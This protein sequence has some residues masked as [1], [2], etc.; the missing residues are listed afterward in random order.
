MYVHHDLEGNEISLPKL[1][2]EHVNMSFTYFKPSIPLYNVI[3]LK[4]VNTEGRNMSSHSEQCVQQLSCV[5]SD[6]IHF[7]RLI[8]K[9]HHLTQFNLHPLL[10]TFLKLLKSSVSLPL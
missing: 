4:M 5:N 6:T 8:V 3:F 10:T 2:Q 9:S 1:I 7:H